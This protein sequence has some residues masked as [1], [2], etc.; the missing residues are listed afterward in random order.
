VSDPQLW[1]SAIEL[2][3]FFGLVALSYF[4]VFAGTGFFNFAVGTY[5]MVGGL[6]T[7]WL[8]IRHS[9][10]LWLALVIALVVTMLLGAITELVVVRPVQ[11][12]SPRSELPALVAVTAVLFAIQQLAG[13][14]FGY[15]TLPGQNLLNIQ[16]INVGSAIVVPS[17][18]T[19]VAVIAV[20]FVVVAVW[21]RYTRTGRLLRAV[22]DSRDAARLL[23]LPVNR[24][25]V[26]AF[27]MSGL[28]AGAA[29]L[30]FASK[31]GVSSTNGLDWALDGFLALVVGGTA[32]VWAPLIG[33]LILG[34]LQIFVPFY[35]GGASLSYLLLVLA[36]VFFGLRPQG[37][38]VRR[39]RV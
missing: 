27:V 28:L 22:G 37:I 23:G 16:P 32:T 21:L 9:I 31:A 15:D 5:A 33:G 7:S 26:V 24:I 18:V 25:R 3:F 20:L 38:F 39:V 11:R 14:E 4:I 12:R 34:A 17:A 6:M 8:V 1:V 36:L 19:L 30:L 10:N 13:V 29:G 2:G 35:F